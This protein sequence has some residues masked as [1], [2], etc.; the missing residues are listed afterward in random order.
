MRRT[1]PAGTVFR[2]QLLFSGVKIG[3]R[4]SEEKGMTQEQ[5]NYRVQQAEQLIGRYR[6]LERER[7]DAGLYEEALEAR[8]MRLEQE[9]SVMYWRERATHAA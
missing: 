5:M 3:G 2:R 1:L 4:P 8:R 6:H 7:E 9:A